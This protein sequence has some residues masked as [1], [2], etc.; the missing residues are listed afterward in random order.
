MTQNEEDGV[1]TATPSKTYSMAELRKTKRSLFVRNDDA[2]MFTL[3][4]KMGNGGKIDL[5]LGPA[6]SKSS[7]CFLPPD[8]LDVPGIAR[9]IALGK[10]TVSPDLEEDMIAL[11]SGGASAS[12]GL[13]DQFQIK[14]EESPQARAIDVRKR[15]EDL[16][17]ASRAGGVV[18]QAM[19][20]KT[21]VDE[22]NNP[23]PFKVEDGRWFDPVKAE[24][25]TSP[26]GDAPAAQV[27][28]D[29]KSITVTR[30]QRLPEEQ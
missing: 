12:R 27:E 29:I 7:I 23:S 5:E 18:P 3:H 22:F 13:L 21:T 1:T 11:M 19:Q 16:V 14:V 10:I 17:A 26:G 4:D 15:T 30:P 20:G 2:M 24:F 6:G 25:I 8:A 9:N 28:H